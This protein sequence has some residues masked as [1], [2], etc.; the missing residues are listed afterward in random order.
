MDFMEAL[1]ELYPDCV[2]VQFQNSGKMFTRE[3]IVNHQ[4]PHDKRF[5]YFAVNVRFLT[6]K[7][8]LIVWVDTIGMIYIV[9]T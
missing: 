1:V 2:A 6:Y 5:I 9:S 7:E 4:I 8:R 3:K